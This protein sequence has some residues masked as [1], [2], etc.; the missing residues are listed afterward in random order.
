MFYFYA[1][2]TISYSVDFHTQTTHVA[3]RLLG[4]FAGNEKFPRATQKISNAEG[5]PDLHFPPLWEKGHCSQ[6]PTT[7]GA[8][9]T[10][11]WA[12]W[13]CSKGVQSSDPK[14]LLSGLES[15]LCSLLA[16][17]ASYA[18]C[19]SFSFLTSKMG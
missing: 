17:W 2:G 1:P 5:S 11:S 14:V 3:M 7:N 10:F 6:R 19:M 16:E 4:T 18:T 15:W 12:S 8:H 13:P 9:S